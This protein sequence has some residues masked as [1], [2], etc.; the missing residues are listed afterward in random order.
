MQ[1]LLLRL[2]RIQGGDKAGFAKEEIKMLNPFE[3]TFQGFIGVYGEISG[4]NRESRAV[5]DFCLQK[6]GDEPAA[7]IVP[8]A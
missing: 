5:P 6:V 1:R 8:Y 4:D 7:M 3:V 2:V